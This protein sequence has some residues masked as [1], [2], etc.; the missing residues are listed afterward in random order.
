VK[1]SMAQK[2][3]VFVREATGLVRELTSWDL[4]NVTYGQIMPAVG[5]VYIMSWNAFAFPNDNMFV[6]FLFGIPVVA[7]VGVLYS[8]LSIAMPRSG[9]DYIWNS[10]ILH[11]AVGFT[12]SWMITFVIVTWIGSAGALFS[13]FFFNVFLATL[14]TMFN[15]PS[16]VAASTAFTTPAVELLVTTLIIAVLTVLMVLGRA[17]W[18]FMRILFF[19][20]MIGSFVNIAYLA[21]VS[22]SAFV[23]AFNAQYAAQGWSY[24]T[25]IQTAV[26][27]GYSMGWTLGASLPALA[28]VMLG[29]TGF[30]WSA[31]A[32]GEARRVSRSIPISILGGL[33]IGGGMFAAWA[34]TIY[35]AFGYDFY[36]AANY[37]FN[38][39]P[40]SGLPVIPTVNQLFTLLPQNPILELLS[41]LAFGLCWL[42][43]IPT[44]FVPITR[45]LFAWSF[46]RIMPSNL[47]SVSDRFH[48]PVLSI[49]ICAILGEIGA[50]AYIY[51]SLFA[52]FANVITMLNLAFLITGIAGILFPYRLK[53]TFENAPPIVKKKLAG[54]PLVSIFGV[55]TVIVE[56]VI[57]YSAV[58]NPNVGGA[59]SPG[60]FGM[61]AGVTIA[62]PIIYYISKAWNKRKG[63]DL[64]LVYSQLPPE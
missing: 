13:S 19:V 30:N 26:K 53:S 46:D 31:Y 15:A 58:A 41:A 8:L 4:F 33:L 12:T 37:L 51:T 42:W 2:Q 47:A 29:Y 45:N 34:W 27:N 57:I 25:V 9:G 7:V 10:R 62:A 16:L 52:F 23:Q 36:S 40:N 21:T 35:N 60:S 14:G 43:L 50:I 3:H 56:A 61:A 48:T 28:Y 22:N 54:I 64:G 55:L 5:I 1:N 6:S 18:R 38:G 49:L 17:V 20:V 24:N 11:P 32:A 59:V 63:I 44:Y 39:Y